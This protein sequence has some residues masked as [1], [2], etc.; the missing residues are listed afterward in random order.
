MNANRLGNRWGRL[1]GLIRADPL[2]TA[3][4][5]AGGI[6]QAEE[7]ATSRAILISMPEGVCCTDPAGLVVWCN[8][9]AERLSGHCAHDVIGWHYLEALALEDEAGRRLPAA[10]GPLAGCIAARAPVYW[11]CLRLIR[12]D[13]Q[14]VLVG[15]SAAPLR[16]RVSD[17]AAYVLVLRELTHQREMEEQKAD[18]IGVVSHELRTPLSHIK[19]FAS[20]LR[21]PDVAWDEPTCRE[22]LAAI[23]AEADRLARLVGDLLDLCFVEGRGLDPRERVPTLPRALVEG[24]LARAQGLL[25][26]RP[27]RVE[28][29]AALPPVAVDAAHLERVLANLVE[30]AAK[31]SPPV[32]P[33]TIGGAVAEGRL[34]LR[35]EDEGPGIPPEYL[36]RVFEK[37]FRLPPAG[38]AAVPGVG[39]GLAI[40]HGIVRAHGGRIWAENRRAGGARFIVSLPLQAGGAA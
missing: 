6:G 17:R 33:I 35:V 19:G 31:Y 2:G 21:Q 30:N 20:T 9:A 22:F 10:E 1:Q 16:E 23:E 25:A 27:L 18:L 40:C 12:T 37:F 13:G 4:R 3:G 29:P 15:L 34:E 39:L 26:G 8:P 14:R 5:G 24:G 36:E 28:V 38:A 32:R 11:P 7:H